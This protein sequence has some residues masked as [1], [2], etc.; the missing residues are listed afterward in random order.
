MIGKETR[1]NKHVRR[2]VESG[3]DM[4]KRVLCY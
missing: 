2:G 3:V 4:R 1:D